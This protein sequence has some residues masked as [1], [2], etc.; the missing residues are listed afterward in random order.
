MCLVVVMSIVFIGSVLD[1]CALG[2]GLA[3]YSS[4]INYIKLILC[5]WSYIFICFGKCLAGYN[6]TYQTLFFF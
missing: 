6:V 4:N 2:Q 5:K 3:G 1:I